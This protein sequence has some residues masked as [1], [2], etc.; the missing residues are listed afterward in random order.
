MAQLPLQIHAKHL[1]PWRCLC[2]AKPPPLHGLPNQEHAPRYS[3]QASLSL[4][5]SPIFHYLHAPRHSSQAS[6]SQIK[7]PA[8]HCLRWSSQSSALQQIQCCVMDNVFKRMFPLVE[9]SKSF[10]LWLINCKIEFSISALKQKPIKL[11]RCGK[12]CGDFCLLQKN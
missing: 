12:R 2:F 6:L 1:R 9:L 11:F 5:K 8:F 4:I 3:R 7:P 10:N